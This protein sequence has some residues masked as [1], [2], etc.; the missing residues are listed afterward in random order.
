MFKREKS[1]KQIESSRNTRL[2]I[3]NVIIP[4]GTTA[5]SLFAA[6]YAGNQDFRNEVN[7]KMYEMKM[8]FRSFK[9]KFF[10]K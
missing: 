4:V 2:W 10:K 5:A 7:W 3:T 6:L 1:Y 9:A 8:N